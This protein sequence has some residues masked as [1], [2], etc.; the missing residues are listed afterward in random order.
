[1]FGGN[2]E[3]AAKVAGLELKATV[4]F[5]FF[6]KKKNCKIYNLSCVDCVGFN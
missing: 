6:F 1:V 4:L 3:S 5:R 2:D